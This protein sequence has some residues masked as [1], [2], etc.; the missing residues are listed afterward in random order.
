[1]SSWLLGIT[2]VIYLWVALDYYLQGKFGMGL[3]FLA[4]ATANLG[5]ILANRGT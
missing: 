4:Y 3:A 5:F 2:G 1:V